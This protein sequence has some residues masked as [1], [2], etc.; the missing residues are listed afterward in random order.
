MHHDEPPPLPAGKSQSHSKNAPR[1]DAR[2]L[3]YQLTGVDLVAIDGL[4]DSSVQLSSSEVGTDMSRFPTAKH[5]CSWLGLA[6]HHAISG[7]KVL[8]RHTLK[9]T[10]RAGQAFRLAAQTLARSRTS[11]SL[12][13]IASLEPDWGRSGPSSPPPTRSPAPSTICSSTAPPSVT[14]APNTTS[15]SRRQLARLAKQAATL[16]FTLQPSPD[17]GSS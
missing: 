10:N 3:L 6:P 16:G 17:R 9:T 12:P 15:T 2:T 11:A 1:Y 13:S 8:S 7:G 14:P 4:S 5:F